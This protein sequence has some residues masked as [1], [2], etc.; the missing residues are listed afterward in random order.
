MTDYS[1]FNRAELFSL[2]KETDATLMAKEAAE[3]VN[4]DPVQKQLI[5]SLTAKMTELRAA[6]SK[7]STSA[8]TS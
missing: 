2:L 4:S 8:N 7:L 5:V 1:I 3:A 6:I